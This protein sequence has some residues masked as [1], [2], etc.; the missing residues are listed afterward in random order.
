MSGKR[1]VKTRCVK[2][3]AYIAY[4]L[5]T[6]LTGYQC[7]N[8]SP[9]KNQKMEN[10]ICTHP[11]V[12]FSFS[13]IIKCSWCGYEYPKPELSEKTKRVIEQLCDE[14]V[15]ASSQIANNQYF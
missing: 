12:T 13:G 15:H 1:T 8:A 11:V 10:E 2:S 7:P 4:S 3:N 9:V 5:D 6:G 14:S